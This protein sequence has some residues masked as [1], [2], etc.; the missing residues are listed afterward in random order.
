MKKIRNQDQKLALW[1]QR[2][3]QCAQ[4]YEAEL[5]RM[6]EDAA[7]YA[8]TKEISGAVKKAQNVRNI[9][10]ELIES[11]VDSTVPQPRVSARAKEDTELAGVI[12]DLLRAQ[13]NRLP[14]EQLND[15]DE[16]NTYIAG[17]SFF[18]VEWDNLIHTH[19][20]VGDLAVAVRHPRQI[21]P[22]AGT[23]SLEESDYVFLR[24]AMTKAAVKRRYGVE[25][26]DEPDDA[27]LR[28]TQKSASDEFITQNIAYYRNDEGGIGLFSWVNDT[29]LEDCMDYQARR[30][31]VCGH[32][33][34]VVTGKECTVCGA[35]EIVQQV[36]EWET[37]R[38]D[39]LRGDGSKIPAERTVGKTAVLYR[40]DGTPYLG[41]VAHSEKTKI[42]YYKA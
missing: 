2:L 23:V 42:P 3:A 29:V 19:T 12:E 40:A 16:R 31:P 30:L 18:H 15:L 39:I 27:V 35:R 22:Q 32:C 34:A 38:T 6:D 26:S 37:L 14:F 33:G 10:F 41:S 28:D 8:G 25:V 17:G 11:E 1:Q 13:L 7:L 4:A 9:V 21:L 5:I 36:Q 20:A 24:V